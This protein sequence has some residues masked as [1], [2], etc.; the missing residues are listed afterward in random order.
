[1]RNLFLLIFLPFL[2]LNCDRNQHPLTDETVIA[3]QPY[4]GFESNYG[5]TVKATLSKMY[6]VQVVLLE[7]VDIPQRAFVNIKSARYR[8]D[9]LIHLLKNDVV[10]KDYDYVIGLIGADISC[11]KY[12]DYETKTIKSPAHK[13]KDWGIFGLGFRPG[14]SCI[15]STFRLKKSTSKENFIARLKKVSCHEVGHNLGLPHCPNKECIM[16]DAAETI[17]TVDNVEL[18]LCD[19]CKKKIGLK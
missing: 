18:H 15:V 8:A 2:L 5:D 11:T 4:A 17:K 16:Q 13:Y 9:T 14:K 6:G 1:M 19:A 7:D 3:I 10:Y 12:S